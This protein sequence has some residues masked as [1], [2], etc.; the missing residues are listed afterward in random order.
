MC[1]ADLFMSKEML[2]VGSG[3]GVEALFDDMQ[4]VASA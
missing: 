4:T 3:V 1:A 2:Y